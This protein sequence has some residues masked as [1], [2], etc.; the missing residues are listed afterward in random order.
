MKKLFDTEEPM[1][2]ELYDKSFLLLGK[3]VW[4]RARYLYNV[5]SL[6]GLLH[7]IQGLIYNSIAVL[8]AKSLV[9]KRVE[10]EAL[11]KH[12]DDVRKETKDL[13][14]YIQTYLKISTKVPVNENKD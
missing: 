12:L 6:E 11:Q 10:K 4:L 5:K 1:M 8:G 3:L 13:N 9:L 7:A 14:D 2:A